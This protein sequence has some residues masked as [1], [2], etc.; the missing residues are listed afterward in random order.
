LTAGSSGVANQFIDTSLFDLIKVDI[1]TVCRVARIDG[2]VIINESGIVLNAGVL[3]QLPD[4]V[5]AGQGA[6]SA[7]ASVGSRGGL[8]LKIS[9]D[10]PISVYRDGVEVRRAG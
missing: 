1:E 9:H 2:A 3:L 10:G 7:A 8:A 5:N 4:F 6:R